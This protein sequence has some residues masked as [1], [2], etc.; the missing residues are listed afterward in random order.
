MARFNFN[1]GIIGGGIGGM[2]AAVALHR[3]GIDV[4]V[5][6]RAKA[7]REVGAGLMLWPN[8]TRVLGELGLLEKITAVSGR[9]DHFIVRSRT[10]A[11]LM[12][13]GLGQFDVPALCTP[14]SD[15]LGALISAL[16]HDRIRLGH[17]VDDLVQR[18]SSVR[19]Y[20]ADQAA[21]EHD[22]V[23]GADGLR[24]RVRSLVLGVHEPIYRGYMVWRG[25]ARLKGAVPTG[26]NSESWGRGK[27]FGILNTGGDRF[28]WYAT[29]NADADHV[30]SPEGRKRELLQM[31]AGWHEPVERLIAATE[32]PAILKNGAY[33]LAPLR[34]W[35]QGRVVLLG[36]AAHPC[37]PNLGL[38]GCMALEDA[39]VLA[40]SFCKEP[41]PELA[42]RRYET[43][44][45]KRTR[46][47]Q[48]RSLMMGSVGQWENRLVTGGR[49]VVTSMLTAK[50]FERNLR[51]VY[52]YAT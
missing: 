33:D 4:T 16:P 3:A 26:S 41:T 28:T 23:V 22:L 43:L 42:L 8:A 1:I 18:K 47:V 2:A 21:I 24:S 25:L 52:S 14:R 49:E 6:E 51:R 34:R 32:E 31:F 39:L 46:H 17:H 45:R 50:I 29:T 10:G 5:Y 37:T 11:I 15:L 40:K 48:R 38:G 12:N 20:F 27:R 9:S 44:R 35:G 13:I 36:D 30:D 19:L 7:L